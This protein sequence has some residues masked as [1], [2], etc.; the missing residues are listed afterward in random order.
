MKTNHRCWKHVFAATAISGMLFAATG[1]IAAG[2]ELTIVTSFAADQTNVFK[3]AFQKAHPDITVNIINKGTSAGLKYLQETA[4]NNKTDLF[5]VSS[6][7]AFE[8]LKANKLLEKFAPDTKG[9]ASEIS[10][11]QIDDPDGYF[12]G[13]AL[14]GYGFMWNT[15]YL[16]SYKLPAPQTWDDLT[17]PI[18]F[19]HLGISAPSRSGTTHMEI[20]TVLQSQGWDKGW[21]TIKKIGGNAKL[22]SERSFGVP[23]GVDSGEFGI[24]LVIDYFGFTSKAAGFPIKFS[25]LSETPLEPA[26][27]GVVANAPHPTAA[28]TFINFVLSPEGQALLFNPKVM[29]LPINKDVY[30]HAPEGIPNPFEGQIK[31]SAHF[32]TALSQSRYNVVNSLYDVMITYRFSEL[33]AAVKAIDDAE[34]AL[35]GKHNAQAEKLIDE[36]KA[37]AFGVPVSAKQAADPSFNGIFKVKRKTAKVKVTGRQAEV[38]KG[39][40]NKVVENYR[41]AEDLAKKAKAML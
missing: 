41:K 16:E 12:F 18:Y 33:Q 25:Y 23:E 20:E 34:A 17:K 1:A 14:S 9:T 19:K 3:Q 5:W 11:H 7:D 28:H 6:P 24:G 10:G 35:K 13:F 39:W 30:K 37:L 4:G 38:E 29:R 8:V 31:A 36:A 40:D 27:I 26:T 22:I 32:D 2:Q 15:R 21:A